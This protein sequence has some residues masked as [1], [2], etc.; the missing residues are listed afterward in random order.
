MNANSM[1]VSASG[2]AVTITH[3]APMPANP[4]SMGTILYSASIEDM[5]KVLSAALPRSENVRIPVIDLR[6]G[7]AVLYV[8]C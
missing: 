6:T 5:Y 7:K 2:N 1:F 4:E 3:M 8:I